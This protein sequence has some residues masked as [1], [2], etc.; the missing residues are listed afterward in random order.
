MSKQNLNAFKGKLAEDASL[1][2][3]MKRTLSDGGKKS[4]ASVDELVAFAKTRGYDFSVDEARENI[5]LSDQQLD[6]VAGGAVD[7]FIKYDGAYKVESGI[8]FAN[9][10]IASFSWG[11]KK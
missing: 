2:E 1:R 4:T 8:N 3:E 10:D 7:A 11:V 5:E 9:F 6:A